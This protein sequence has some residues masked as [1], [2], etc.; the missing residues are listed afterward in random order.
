MMKDNIKV[1]GKCCIFYYTTSGKNN[2]SNVTP[3]DNGTNGLSLKYTLTTH[4]DDHSKH[5]FREAFNIALV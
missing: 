2:T 5:I 1:K 3:A 4:S